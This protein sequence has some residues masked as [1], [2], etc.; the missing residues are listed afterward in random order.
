MSLNDITQLPGNETWKQFYVNTFNVASNMDVGGNLDVSGSLTV[1]GAI[2]GNIGASGV[3][4][5]QLLFN[6]SSTGITYVVPPTATYNQFGN[7]VFI[8][9]S[10]QLSNIGSFAGDAIPTVSGLVIPVGAAV[11]PSNISCSW[12]AC[13]LDTNA[14]VVTMHSVPNSTTFTLNQCHN[15]GG[16]EIALYYM[17]MTNNTVINFSGFYFSS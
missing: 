2:N 14:T 9:G 15:T 16:S 12:S 3:W 7:I 1:S 10:I 6:G 4:T 8:N 13:P 11:N 5:P 17:F